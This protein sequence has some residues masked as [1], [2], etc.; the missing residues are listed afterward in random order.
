MSQLPIL[1]MKKVVERNESMSDIYYRNGDE[2]NDTE[3]YL[4]TLTKY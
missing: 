1:C 4:E 2:K 3:I